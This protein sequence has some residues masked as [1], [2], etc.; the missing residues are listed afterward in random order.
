MRPRASAS[1]AVTARS[2]CGAGAGRRPGPAR[3]STSCAVPAVGQP[4][5]PV[6]ALPLLGEQAAGHQQ[7]E[8]LARGGPGDAGGGGELAGRP[9]AAVEQG[10][11]H[12]GAGRVGQQA[13]R[14]GRAT[15]R[16]TGAL[17]ASCSGTPG[18]RDADEAQGT[19]RHGEQRG[20]LA[21]QRP[22][23]H[24]RHRRHQVGGGAHPAGAGARQRVGPG[25]ERDRGRERAEVDDP[26]QR[27]DARVGSLV[28]QGGRERQAGDGPDRA[29]QP[30]D[31]E[32]RQPRQQRLLRD[33]PDRVADRGHHAQQHARPVRRSRPEV[34]APITSDAGE[35]DGAA[36]DQRAREALAEQQ[37]G[38]QR[39]DQRPDVD[40]HRGGAGVDPLLGG[41]ERDVVDAEPEQAADE[42]QRPVAPGRPAAAAADQ[43]R[44]RRAPGCRR[45]AGPGSARPGENS[46]PTCRIAT[47]ADAH[48][49]TVTPAAARAST[50]ERSVTVGGRLLGR[51]HGRR[52]YDE[53]GSAATE[54]SAALRAASASR[55]SEPSVH[56]TRYVCGGRAS[57][58]V[59]HA[60]G[61]S[62]RRRDGD[63]SVADGRLRAIAAQ[64]G[65]PPGR[66][67]R[68]AGS[69]SLTSLPT[70]PSPPPPPPPPSVPA[71]RRAGVVGQLVARLA[72]RRRRPRGRGRRA[73]AAS[74]RATAAMSRAASIADPPRSPRHLLRT[75]PPRLAC[76]PSPSSCAGDQVNAQNG[77]Y[78]SG[79]VTSATVGVQRGQRARRR[80][81]AIA[82][83]CAPAPRVI[84]RP[85]NR[86]SATTG[87]AVV[88]PNGVM[89]P[90][91]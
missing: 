4:Q 65:R 83:P 70:L 75:D 58:Y 20:C 72:E 2:D 10:E 53:N 7:V 54:L 49:T 46:W 62:R 21:Q 17:T 13:R 34:A 68:R 38:E 43:R 91:S 50:A 30:G 89:V 45:A 71:L 90:R 52:R 63:R 85:R 28:D 87:Q 26:G 14:A 24:D 5:V 79:S 11:A 1:L 40:Q 88:E 66:R 73:P 64:L 37:P 3:S 69:A 48:S 84:A 60:D 61:R 77:D 86:S 44:R 41:V 27:R 80:R 19:A 51:R 74:P 55:S 18:D 23:Q 56:S 78:S 22:R 32:R 29:G 6:P 15:R 35:G 12:P 39:E 8:V 33:D 82:T 9:G 67:G 76:R 16:R 25:G 81:R 47:K 31:L 57:A 36:D 42:Q 59:D